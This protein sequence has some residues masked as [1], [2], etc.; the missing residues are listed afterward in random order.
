MQRCCEPLPCLITLFLLYVAIRMGVN[1]APNDIV[2]G[3]VGGAP[4]SGSGWVET[5]GFQWPSSSSLLHL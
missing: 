3:S 2:A 4:M 1:D 5:F